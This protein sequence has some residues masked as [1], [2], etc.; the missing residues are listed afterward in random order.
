MASCMSARL[1]TTHSSKWCNLLWNMEP[2]LIPSAHILS[3]ISLIP[4]SFWSSNGLSC[5]YA[6]HISSYCFSTSQSLHHSQ[7]LSPLLTVQPVLSPLL[8]MQPVLSPLLTMQPVLS[9]LLT[10]QPVL[11]PLL[12]MQ[13]VLSPLLTMEPVLSQSTD[14]AASSLH[15][16]HYAASSLSSLCVGKSTRMGFGA[17]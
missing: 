16:T 12:T 14:Y 9:P 11:S 1:Y 5:V 3:F 4:N 17:D 6:Q 7:N 13:P 8:T 2:A 10:M 15:S